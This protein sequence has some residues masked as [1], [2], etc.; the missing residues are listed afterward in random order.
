MAERFKALVLK[1]SVGKL[2]VGSNPSLSANINKIRNPQRENLF[3]LRN[4]RN[5]HRPR[6]KTKKSRADARLNPY[7][8]G[9]IAEAITFQTAATALLISSSVGSSFDSCVKTDRRKDSRVKAQFIITVFASCFRAAWFGVSGA[10]LL[11]A[12][13]AKK[14]ACPIQLP[15]RK[16]VV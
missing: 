9:N 8:T 15:D 16:S 13:A 4:H 2:T 12:I 10:S 5:H 3:P 6:L 1:T 7:P 14:A 11:I